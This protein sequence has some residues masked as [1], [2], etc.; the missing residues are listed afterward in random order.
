MNKYSLQILFS[1]LIVN[2]I[3]LSFSLA[4]P[5]FSVPNPFSDED[6]VISFPDIKESLF[7]SA[8]QKNENAE[9]FL[10]KY[11]T[12]DEN[13]LIDEKPSVDKNE[14]NGF[15]I[16]PETSGKKAL[17]NFFE[18]LEK[19]SKTGTV[20]VAHYGDSQIEGDR[21]TSY[22]RENFQKEFGGEGIG[23]A[24]VDDITDNVNYFRSTSENW[25]RYNVFNHAYSS[26]KYALSGLVFKYGN[27]KSKK[28]NDEQEPKGKKKKKQLDEKPAEEEQPSDSSTVLN[29][30][31]LSHSLLADTWFAVKSAFLSSPRDK[32]DVV[33]ALRGRVSLNFVKNARFSKIRVFYGKVGDECEVRISDQKTG[34]VIGTLQLNGDNP[35]NLAS[36]AFRGDGSSIR[37]DISSGRNP[38]IYGFF[39][40]GDRGVQVD[41]F[42]IRGHSGDGLLKIDK[43]FLSAQYD[44]LNVKLII[45]QFGMNIMPTVTKEK[46]LKRVRDYY[47]RLYAGIR[48]RAKNS[49]VLVVGPGDMGVIRRGS[50]VSHPY[51]GEVVKIMK[52]C[53][54]ENGC[55]FW[56]T[57]E[58]MGGENSI[59]AWAQKGYAARDG[60]FINRGQK[61]IAAELF[62]GINDS[63]RQY[64]D[65]KNSNN[66]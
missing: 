36:T 31:G 39:F 63:Y 1:I 17:D 44:E 33:A 3:L 58:L 34:T 56:N 20:R 38:E 66:R 46:D 40:D 55:A 14:E 53:A 13:A 60:H 47:N 50:S 6:L 18:A 49:S 43:E 4:G 54:I 26:G 48:E 61:I 2:G 35:F 32:T 41:N 45:L 19:E 28:D 24:P 9:N 62:K 52:E 64:L 51:I 11:E 27:G 16:N 29:K 5:E 37:F 42:A 25:E 7:K 10:S 23:Y 30:Y 57:Y 59:A 22:L 15:L 21:I 12:A 65:N 8:E